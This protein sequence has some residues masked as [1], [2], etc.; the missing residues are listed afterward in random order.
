LKD[1][2]DTVV[3]ALEREKALPDHV[4]VKPTDKVKN[5]FE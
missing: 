1:V 3:A 2:L 5:P 4:Q